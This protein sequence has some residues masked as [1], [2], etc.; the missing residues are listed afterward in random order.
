MSKLVSVVPSCF[1]ISDVVPL[2]TPPISMVPSSTLQ[3]TWSLLFSNRVWLV[4]AQVPVAGLNCSQVVGSSL[5]ASPPHVRRLS[6]VWPLLPATMMEDSR[7]EV[8][9]EGRITSADRISSYCSLSQ[10]PVIR[11]AAI[12]C[13]RMENH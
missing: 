2:L 9:V 10:P 13:L 5:T 12:T 7:H 3:D 4:K 1:T 8:K 11:M 6:W